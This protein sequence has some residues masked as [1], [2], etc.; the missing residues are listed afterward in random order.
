MYTCTCA[1]GYTGDNCETGE[2]KT[3]ATVFR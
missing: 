3:K 2:R 1:A